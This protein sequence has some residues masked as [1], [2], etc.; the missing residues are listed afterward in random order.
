MSPGVKNV[1]RIV[2]C[3]RS[4]FPVVVGEPPRGTALSRLMVYWIAL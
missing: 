4:D 2:L 3:S 1:V